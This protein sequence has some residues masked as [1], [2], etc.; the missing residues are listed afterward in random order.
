VKTLGRLRASFKDEGVKYALHLTASRY[1]KDAGLLLILDS[2]SNNIRAK[3]YISRSE[4]ETFERWSKHLR[5]VDRFH[6]PEGEEK[7]VNDIVQYSIEYRKWKITPAE[8]YYRAR[9]NKIDESQK[10][11]ASEMGAPPR[12]SARAGRLNPVGIPYLYVSWDQKTCIAEVRPW[13]GACVSVARFVPKKPLQVVNLNYSAP[14][15]PDKKLQKGDEKQYMNFV[16]FMSLTLARPQDPD[17]EI[18]YIPTQY[19]AEKFKRRGFDGVAYQSVLHKHGTNMVLFD[20]TVV[21]AKETRFYQINQ[22]AYSH[23]E[24]KNES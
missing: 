6:L 5:F 22:V 8:S 4:R 7:L 24:I 18:S 14:K 19:I 3:I 9:V 13:M 1:K 17:D 10:K 11:N 23:E 21:E 15:P 2:L 16:K 20:P 12:E